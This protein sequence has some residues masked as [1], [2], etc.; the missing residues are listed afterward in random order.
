MG[1]WRA[2]VVGPGRIG[3]GFIGQLLRASGAEVVF[4]GRDAIAANLSRNRGYRVR[5]TT[6]GGARENRRAAPCGS[7]RPMPARTS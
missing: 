7:V 2:V 1:A 4:V 5:L 6:R 3:C